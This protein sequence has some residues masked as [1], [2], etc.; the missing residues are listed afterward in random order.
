M[1]AAIYNEIEPYASRWLDNL[2][3]AGHIAPG[4][5]DTRSIVELQPDDVRAASQFHAFAGI[6][7]WSH[8]LKLAGWPEDARVWTGSCPCQPFSVAGLGRGVADERHLWPEWFRLI[9]ECRPPVVFGEQVAGPAGLDWFDAVS[10]DLEGVGYAVAAACLPACGVGAPHRR[11]RIIFVAHANAA[12]RIVLRRGGLLDGERS[13]LGHDADRCRAIVADAEAIGRRPR[14]AG[15][16]VRGQTIEPHRHGDDRERGVG[17]GTAARTTDGCRMGDADEDAGRR[18]GGR[19]P[20]AQASGERPDGAHD[21]PVGHGPRDAGFDVGHAD[22]PGPQGRG[23]RLYSADEWAARSP[24]MAGATG[25]FWAGADW[26][27]CDDPIRGEVWRPV[28]PGLEP[29]AHGSTGRVGRLRAYGNAIVAPLVAEFI[30]AAAE[31]IV[32]PMRL[33]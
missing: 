32:I 28:E 17:D 21:G 15:E 24:S 3:G 7:V 5:V 27:R 23:V 6:G 31:A 13:A 2:I 29:L 33:A 12:G 1:S 22:V 26:V 14:R 18:D 19:L 8:A 10:T 11:E 20:R 30:R 16:A 9:R 4:R 25:G